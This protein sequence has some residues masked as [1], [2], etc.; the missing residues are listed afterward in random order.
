IPLSR[1]SLLPHGGTT[2]RRRGAAMIGTIVS[3][4]ERVQDRDRIRGLGERPQARKQG[5]ER[6]LTEPQDP[7]LIG[8]S[9]DQPVALIADLLG[10]FALP[11]LLLRQAFVQ[12][13]DT[14][15]GGLG[16]LCECFLARHRPLSSPRS[17]CWPRACSCPS[18]CSRCCNAWSVP[19][20]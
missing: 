3:T 6:R 18:A 7:R 15:R 14:L 8:Q 17:C 19:S 9:P 16:A 20:S 5:S 2:I 10:S 11:L 4:D 1:R 13:L 12:A